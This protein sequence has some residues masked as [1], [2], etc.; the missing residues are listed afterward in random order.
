MVELVIV[1]IIIGVV[2][3]IAVPRISRS[4]AS[5]SG[6]ALRADLYALRTAIDLYAMEHDKNYPS[7]SPPT[8][9]EAQLTTYTDT[10]GNTN[11]TRT[12]PYI[13]G[14]Y[15]RSIPVLNLGE[16]PNNG[17]GENAVGLA[18]GAAFGWVYDNAIGHIRANSGTAQDDAG[19]LF[20]DY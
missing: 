9:F 20:V 10:D 14:P 2:A 19:T 18:A 3:S 15:L 6:S 7:V 5:A 17:K 8:K 13:Y 4:A 12:I 11:P 1:V 16:G